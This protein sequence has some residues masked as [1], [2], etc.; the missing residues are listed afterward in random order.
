MSFGYLEDNFAAD[1]IELGDILGGDF[2][3]LSFALLVGFVVAHHFNGA[4]VGG[5]QD[6]PVMKE[7]VFRL[8]DINEGGF[9]AV[10]EVLDAPLEDGAYFACVSGA[11]H[12]EFLKDAVF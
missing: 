5:G 8:P 1:W 9:E 7:G 10:L 3:L 11:L 2:F 12:L 6:V 4:V